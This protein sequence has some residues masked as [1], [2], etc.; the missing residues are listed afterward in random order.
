MNRLHAAVGLV[1]AWAA[2]TCF[3]AELNAPE[4]PQWRGPK[5][6]GLSSDTGLLTKWPKDGPKLVWEAQGAGRG[7]SSLAITGGRIYTMGDRLPSADSTDT[8]VIA[9][10]QATGKEIWK[11]QIGPAHDQP[12]NRHGARSTPTVDGELLYALSPNGNLVCLES[13]T[14]KERW[15][16]SLRVDFKGKKGDGWE[17]SE[18]PLVDGERVICT[19]GG[20]DA[21]MV[22]LNKRTGALV[23]KASV[24]DSTG[25]G[26]ASIVTAEINGV[27]M[28]VQTIA[29]AALGVNAKDGKVLWTYPI[30]RTTAV[31]PTPIVRHDHVFVCA[32]YGRGGAL[33]KL[34]P[35]GDG[36]IKA[37]EVY[38]F[39]RAL[40]NKHGGVLLISDYLYAGRDETPV[41]FCAELMTG[42]V[43]WE[44][45]G[46]GNASAA[47][48][49]ADGHLYIR[50]A[51][52]QMA[53]AKAS[54][55]EYAEISTFK[56]PHSGE[57][58]SWSHPVIVGG[59]LYLREQDW[60]MCYD[61][62]G[63]TLE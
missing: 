25:A 59:R 18:S 20:A 40:A 51:N 9:F 44:K 63:P 45:R 62:R 1:L 50:F 39:N 24:A 60:I 42:K 13:A 43:R 35:T 15:R 32:G 4:W 3:A 34:T 7:Y 48:A 6:D 58:P 49:Y 16:K 56:I 29:S 52:A 55:D 31:I 33:L 27:R 11:S 10:D 19:P 5:R 28:Y 41:I 2:A 14:G 22:A 8:H 36:G 26:H 38:P 53:L 46:T 47:V 57:L 54:P 61:V 17:Y 23:W 21:T 30:P 12:P 37:D